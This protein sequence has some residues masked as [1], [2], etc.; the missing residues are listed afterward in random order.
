MICEAEDC[1]SSRTTYP[2]LPLAGIPVS[3]KDT[4]IV[5]GF[6]A[7]VGYSC[8]TDRPYTKDGGLV[9]LLRDAGK[10]ETHLEKGRTG[11]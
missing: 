7:S 5:G 11:C 2:G 3:L 10:R 8:K 4:I 9:R 1:V 6:D